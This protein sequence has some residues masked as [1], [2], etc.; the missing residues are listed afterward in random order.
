MN[1]GQFTCDSEMKKIARKK[2]PSHDLLVELGEETVGAG[3]TMGSCRACLTGVP[4]PVF[5]VIK[6]GSERRLS[7]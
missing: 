5:W 6:I 4:A 3:K 1:P 7:E 2:S